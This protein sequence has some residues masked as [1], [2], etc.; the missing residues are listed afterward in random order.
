[1]PTNFCIVKKANDAYSVRLSSMKLGTHTFEFE[2]NKAFFEVIEQSLIED[3]EVFVKVNWEKKETMM[4]VYFSLL[5]TVNT[6][7]DRCNDPVSVP[8]QGQYKLVYKFGTDASEDENLIVLDPESIEVDLRDQLYEF[9]VIALPNRIV[10]PEGECNEE[11]MKLYETYIVNSNEP[12]PDDPDSYRD[13][14]EDWDDEDEE[15]LRNQL[16]EDDDD[17]DWDDE[18]DNDDDVDPD[19]PIDPRWAALQKLKE[20]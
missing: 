12:E 3:G 15:W 2:L 4:V 9:A 8:I 5:G 16:G 1:M 10:H 17:E 11:V 14:D 7:C 6:T 19:K 18:D 20:E 13:D